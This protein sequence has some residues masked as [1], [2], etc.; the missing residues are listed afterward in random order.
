[1]HP[2]FPCVSLNENEANEWQEPSEVS[3]LA[4]STPLRILE[5]IEIIMLAIKPEAK[6]SI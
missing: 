4:P 2:T 3:S 6:E 5:T 1:M